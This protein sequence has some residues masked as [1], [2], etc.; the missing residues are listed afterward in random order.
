M[1]CAS[2]WGISARR[3]PRPSNL[4]SSVVACVPPWFP[5]QRPLCARASPLKLL[6]MRRKRPPANKKLSAERRSSSSWLRKIQQLWSER[7]SRCAVRT[8]G[9]PPRCKALTQVQA[10]TRCRSFRAP[11]QR[12]RPLAYRWLPRVV[13]SGAAETKRCRSPSLLGQR[14]WTGRSST[15]PS[16][17][18]PSSNASTSGPSMDSPPT[19]Q[20]APWTVSR[21]TL[22]GRQTRWSIRTSES[23]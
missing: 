17:C 6:R 21:P 16:C 5:R 20:D 8:N 9:G 13:R 19:L 22:P 18:S 15:S 3:P 23:C 11:R 4:C 14:L 7:R 12:A 1:N 2:V 10:Y